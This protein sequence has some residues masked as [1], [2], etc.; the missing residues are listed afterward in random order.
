MVSGGLG[1]AGTHLCRQIEAEGHE[2]IALDRSLNNELGLG[3]KFVLS[4]LYDL[5]DV[6]DEKFD[7]VF[8]SIGVLTWLPNLG[9]MGPG[10]GPFSEAG[11]RLLHR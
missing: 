7:I 6:L 5:T 10:R 8:T 3:A 11:W 1:F 9:P 2:A 4:N